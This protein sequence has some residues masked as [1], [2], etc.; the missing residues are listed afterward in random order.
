MSFKNWVSK[1]CIQVSA[2]SS[3]WT[4]D[5]DPMSHPLFSDPVLEIWDPYGQDDRQRFLY[6]RTTLKTAF[7]QALIWMVKVIGGN[8]QR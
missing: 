2:L 5:E 3:L 8:N 7:I 4:R 1:H 6:F